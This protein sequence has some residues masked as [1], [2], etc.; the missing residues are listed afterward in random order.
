MLALLS[1]LFTPPACCGSPAALFHSPY[2]PAA[3]LPPPFFTPPTC[4]LRF[5]PPPFSLS[6]PACC[7][8]PAALFHSFLLSSFLTN[9]TSYPNFLITSLIASSAYLS[10]FLLLL[11]VSNLLL[12][13]P[14]T[15]LFIAFVFGK[16]SAQ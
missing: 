15:F 14:S 2:L 10:A 7:G 4:L 13:C 1:F 8:F 16:C 5:F 11:G 12:I 9:S 6:I 3:V